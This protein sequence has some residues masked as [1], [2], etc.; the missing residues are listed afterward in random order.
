MAYQTASQVKMRLT[1]SVLKRVRNGGIQG[2]EKMESTK[3]VR[4]TSDQCLISPNVSMFFLMF[5][6]QY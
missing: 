3:Y 6:G 2:T 4:T 5:Y 1:V